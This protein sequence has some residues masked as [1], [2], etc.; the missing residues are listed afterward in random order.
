MNGYKQARSQ[1]LCLGGGGGVVQSMV[2]W[3]KGYPFV[4]HDERMG[5]PLNSSAQMKVRGFFNIREH[6]WIMHLADYT[7]ISIW[8]VVFTLW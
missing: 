1:V 4:H 2:Q 8:E 5:V 6:S 3:T 7:A